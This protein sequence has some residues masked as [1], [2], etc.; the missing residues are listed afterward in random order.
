MSCLE[1]RR[2]AAVEKD[3]LISKPEPAEP[4][5]REGTA[6]C[7]CGRRGPRPQPAVRPRRLRPGS[8]LPAPAS[9]SAPGG[10]SRQRSGRACEGDPR[11]MRAL[12]WGPRVAR[13]LAAS[14]EPIR[15]PREQAG[16]AAVDPK[17]RHCRVSRIGDSLVTAPTRQRRNDSRRRGPSSSLGPATT[18]GRHMAAR[19]GT[20]SPLFVL[21]RL[22]FVSGP[23]ATA[24]PS[25]ARR[26]GLQAR[27]LRCAQVGRREH[28]YLFI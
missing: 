8:R 22:R 26:T 19:S 6:Q 9:F 21:G 18:R 20:C 12:A 1:S 28:V 17:T 23:R 15:Q 11:H 2:L 14:V 24:A 3:S 7:L 13:R 25:N 16:L 27:L 5:E 10:S 4:A